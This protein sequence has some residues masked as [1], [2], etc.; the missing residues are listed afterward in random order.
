[1]FTLFC[2]QQLGA[3]A[4]IPHRKNI[5]YGLTF[6]TFIGPILLAIPTAHMSSIFEEDPQ[7]EP[8]CFYFNLWFVV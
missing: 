3:S 7:G 4:A 6:V 2:S 5:G 1:M 8:S